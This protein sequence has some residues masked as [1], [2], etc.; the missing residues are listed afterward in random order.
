MSLLVG[1]ITGRR[2]VELTMVEGSGGGA[3][4][5]KEEDGH[6]ASFQWACVLLRGGRRCG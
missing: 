3:S 6:E 2:L 1:L 4:A 5:G